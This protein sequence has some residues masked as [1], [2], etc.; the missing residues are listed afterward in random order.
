M[1]FLELGE[2]EPQVTECFASIMDQ[3]YHHHGK[4]IHTGAAFSGV[5]YVRAD[6]GSGTI[7]F[8]DPALDHWMCQF[9]YKQD[10]LDNVS[11]V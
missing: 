1:T 6:E 7:A 3:P 10:L 2:Y 5:Y 9:K 11:E 4:H 8:E